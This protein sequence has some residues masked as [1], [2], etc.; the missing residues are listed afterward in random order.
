MSGS[1]NREENVEEGRDAR[2][3]DHRRADFPVG[4]RRRRKLQLRETLLPGQGLRLRHTEGVAERDY[5][6]PA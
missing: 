3:V 6:E 5:S 2:Q 4:R 1:R